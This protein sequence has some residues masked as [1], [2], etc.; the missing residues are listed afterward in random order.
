MFS[1]GLI[2]ESTLTGKKKKKK[3]RIAFFSPLGYI[4]G[5]GLLGPLIRTSSHGVNDNMIV[6]MS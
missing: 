5:I 4:S 2:Y 1:F 6:I 3:L